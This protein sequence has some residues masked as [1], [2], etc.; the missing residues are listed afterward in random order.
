MIKPQNNLSKQI[1]EETMIN[2]YKAYEEFLIN[3]IETIE[4][5][6]DL[7]IHLYNKSW[8]DRIDE[9]NIAPAF[10]GLS[11]YSIIGTSLIKLSKLLEFNEKTINIENTVIRLNKFKLQIFNN[12]VER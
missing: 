10:F 12:N 11:G 3:E 4:N 5:M 2:E 9:L 6:F 7:Y 8:I 1:F